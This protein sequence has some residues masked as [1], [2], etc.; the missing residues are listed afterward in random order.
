MSVEFV[1]SV[2]KSHKSRFRCGSAAVAEPNNPMA[3]QD[4]KGHFWGLRKVAPPSLKG[5]QQQT[6]AVELK[7]LKSLRSGSGGSNTTQQQRRP[8]M[9]YPATGGDKN[10]SNNKPTKR[11]NNKKLRVDSMDSA[12]GQVILLHFKQMVITLTLK[13]EKLEGVNLKEV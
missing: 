3:C 9:K 13:G 6:A 7:K 11:L 5:Q 1:V 10:P 2:L 4:T 12:L 8:L